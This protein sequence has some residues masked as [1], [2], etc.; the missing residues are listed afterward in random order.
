MTGAERSSAIG[1]WL[2][3]LGAPLLAGL[4]LAGLLLGATLYVVV[5]VGWWAV[6]R[7]ERRRRLRE[8]ALRL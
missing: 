5:Y 7:L 6:I 8:R 1:Q 3:E 4:P 2:S